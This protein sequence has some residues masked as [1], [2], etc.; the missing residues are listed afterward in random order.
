MIQF[1]ETVKGLVFCGG[2]HGVGKS[3]LCRALAD[4][5]D[6][7]HI[8]AGALLRLAGLVKPSQYGIL[9]HGENQLHIQA[10]LQHYREQHTGGRIIL[11]GHFCLLTQH[12]RIQALPCA[13]FKSL[14]AVVLLVVVDDPSAVSRRL[15]DRDGTGL[16]A[17]LVCRFQRREVARAEAISHA[18]GVPLRNLTPRAPVPELAQWILGLG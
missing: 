4:E 3:S 17:T 12:H 16:D 14:R 8:S 9:N 15:A 7:V 10:A 6:A 5:M 18:L 13:L 11:D 1:A 2:V